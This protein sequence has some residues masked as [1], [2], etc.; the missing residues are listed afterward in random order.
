M[1]NRS[2]TLIGFLSSICIAPFHLS[3]SS[4]SI[5]PSIDSL[6]DAC[7]YFAATFSIFLPYVALAG[8][9]IGVPIYLI[10]MKVGLVTWWMA[11]IAGFAAG[12][13]ASFAVFGQSAI[14]IQILTYTLLGA[15]SG[16]VF[17]LVRSLAMR[18][19]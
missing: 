19:Q 15:F 6:A 18:G 5:E 3:L 1:S 10:S 14:P 7:I 9:L 16:L 17:W 12:A 11:T 2:A 8:L 13:C 4:M